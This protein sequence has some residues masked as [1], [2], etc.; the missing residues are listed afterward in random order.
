MTTPR[1]TTRSMSRELTPGPTVPD[2]A[3]THTKGKRPAAATKKS[4]A[5]GSLGQ[6]KD[7]A[8]LATEN[9]EDMAID[10]IQ[11]GV[12]SAGSR[13]IG[14]AQAGND[15]GASLPGI[16]EEV[17]VE[18]REEVEVEAREEG[19]IVGTGGHVRD[20]G[21]VTGNGTPRGEGDSKSF[22]TEGPFA[23]VVG[24]DVT[25]KE[26]H[27]ARLRTF[28][29]LNDAFQTVLLKALLALS[30][31]ALLYL[32]LRGCRHKYCWPRSGVSDHNSFNETAPYTHV[33][34]SS[35]SQ[36]DWDRLSNE[37]STHTT[38]LNKFRNMAGELTKSE[39]HRVNYFSRGLG[40]IVDPHLTSPTRKRTGTARHWLFG[41]ATYELNTP[42]PAAALA[43]W[44]DIGDCW[45]A[46]PSGDGR[47]QLTVLLPRKIAPTDLVIEHIHRDATLDIGAAPKDIELWVQIH[48]FETRGR[49]QN[50]FLG[51]EDVG[52]IDQDWVRVGVW[53][54]DI[55]GQDNIQTFSIPIALEDFQTAID[56]ASIRVRNNW[57]EQEA[58]LT[59]EHIQRDATLD[60]GAA[61]KE[62][63]LWVEIH[64]PETRNRIRD[65]TFGGED[66]GALDKNWIR[67]GIFHYDIYAQENI[68]TF[69][70][71][72]ALENF[73][74]AI[75]KVS[76]RVRQ[77][78]LEAPA[79]SQPPKAKVPKG[80]KVPQEPRVVKPAVP[81]IKQWRNF[82]TQ[83]YIRY[84]L[85]QPSAPTGNN[86]DHYHLY[87]NKDLPN[88]VS[89]IL[90]IPTNGVRLDDLTVS[91]VLANVEKNVKFDHD[92]MI[93]ARRIPL[94]RDAKIWVI[95]GGFRYNISAQG[96]VRTFN[97][98]VALEGF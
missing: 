56:K 41:L 68:Q 47:A 49:I 67:V 46:P 86:V 33:L 59:V 36:R 84:D 17:E 32:G 95:V 57:G 23:G 24:V 70:V 82:N 90:K 29:L 61:P 34:P 14:V 85:A 21:V 54:Y 91:R 7:S 97:M 50:A 35:V 51:G 38:I 25:P 75:D 60:I 73:Q 63:E 98:P 10:I 78:H 13:L 16:E 20:G 66:L 44:D 15:G 65:A 81:V 94:G 30:L 80:L 92:G 8:V 37:V 48:D 27:V 53:R 12:Q 6:T 45:C 9:S 72:V 62:I 87:I 58:H 77:N 55:Y 96:D 2:S 42:S 39:T 43:P 18:V 89:A 74:V 11:S 83:R 3:T 31:V 69:S 64:D 40:A 93:K 4:T 28:S 5:Y 1:R 52:A 19:R 22:G 26:Q 71:P 76:I 88:T 79:A